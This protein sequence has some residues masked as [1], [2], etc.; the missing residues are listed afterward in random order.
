MGPKRNLNEPLYFR[1]TLP[2]YFFKGQ[3]TALVGLYVT[4][5]VSKAVAE[6]TTMSK[7]VHDI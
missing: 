7:G 2:E 3:M 5:I 4:C 6:L 1:S